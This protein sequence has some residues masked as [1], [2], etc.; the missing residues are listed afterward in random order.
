MMMRNVDYN[1]NLSAD[2]Q[3][4]KNHSLSLS[5][6]YNYNQNRDETN[7]MLEKTNF[8]LGTV[9]TMRVHSFNNT[10]N[11]NHSAAFFY[12]GKSGK[13]SYNA[14]INYVYNCNTPDNTFE[15]GEHFTLRNH[16]NDHM[17]FARL[18]S[19]ARRHWDTD[20][21]MSV[22][23]SIRIIVSTLTDSSAIALGSTCGEELT[24][25]ATI[26]LQ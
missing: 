2:Y 24:A 3:I 9:D 13:W 20:R 25:L 21:T 16:Y 1:V 19:D 26:R 4:N 7:Y 18:R 14:D 5:Y 12:R 6:A 8:G 11:H 22:R 17:N 23:I 10:D 15:R